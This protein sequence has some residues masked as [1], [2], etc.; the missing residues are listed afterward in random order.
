MTFFNKKT[1]VISFELTPYGKSLLANGKLM[2][3]YYE[4]IDDD[5]I[6]DASYGPMKNE[7]QND[8]HARITEE[9]PKLKNIVNISGIETNFRVQES[10]A[11]KIDRLE[12]TKL[13]YDQ[14]YVGSMGRS[15]YSSENSANFQVQ[16]LTSEIAYSEPILTSSIISNMQI[17]QININFNLFASTGSVTNDSPNNYI[18]TSPVYDDGKFIILDFKEPLIYLKEFNSF[19]EKENFEIESYHVET[20][21]LQNDQVIDKIVPLLFPKANNNI[22]NNIYIEP[23][24]TMF[25]NN[26]M[27]DVD[28][29]SL[30]TEEHSEYYFE[31]I[32]DENI[33]VEEICEAVN[34]LEINNQFLDKELLCPDARTDRF[35]L[36]RSRIKPEDL[37]DCD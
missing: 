33:P 13:T 26:E 21:T 37:E 4:F 10:I 11:Q 1:E 24:P 3:K 2:P 31:I 30:L 27:D 22:K 12:N 35:D 32:V 20:V 15:N 9:T 28:L 6:Y 14:G 25:Q 18:N 8:V 23:G 29:E 19:Y 17:P 36:Y 16:M 7:Q 5:V 34:K